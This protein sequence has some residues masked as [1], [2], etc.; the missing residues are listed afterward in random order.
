M[1][2]EKTSVMEAFVP[3][4]RGSDRDRPGKS[5]LPPSLSL[6]R[7][8]M[9]LCSLTSRTSETLGGS[10]PSGTQLSAR[11]LVVVHV[12]AGGTIRIISA[13][14]ASRHERTVYAKGKG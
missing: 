9:F 5:Q 4:E 6:R 7:H 12:E 8:T 13:R 1:L 3:G 14:K 10:S 11:M 2:F